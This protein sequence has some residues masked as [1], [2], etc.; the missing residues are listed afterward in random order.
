MED[1]MRELVAA[2]TVLREQLMQSDEVAEQNWSWGVCRQMQG[3][4]GTEQ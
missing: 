4:Q 1:Q 2:I 3:L